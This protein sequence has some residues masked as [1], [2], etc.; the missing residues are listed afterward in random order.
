MSGLFNSFNWQEIMVALLVLL[1]ILYLL[2]YFRKQSQSHNCD[3]CG[4]ME[5]QKSK[6][7]KKTTKEG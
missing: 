3:D 4:L 2:R 6:N 1:A 7:Q 5:M